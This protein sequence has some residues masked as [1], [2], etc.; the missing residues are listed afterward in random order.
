MTASTL[1]LS[2]AVLAALVFT[3][4]PRSDGQGTG[5]TTASE[6]GRASVSAGGVRI[7]FPPENPGLRLIR[8]ERITKCTATLPAVMPARV[9]ASITSGL[10]SHERMVLFES[11]DVA[12]LYS[13]YRQNRANVERTA[14][15]L[16]RVRE[17]YDNQTATSKDLNEAETDAANARASSAES[18]AK[19][20]GLGFN[21]LELES[22]PTGTIWLICDVPESQ[23]HEVQKGEVVRIVFDAYPNVQFS[24]HADALGEVVDAVTRTVRVR[25]SA[26]NPKGKFLPGMFARVDFGDP[27][28]NIVLLP[29]SAIVTV[30]GSDYVFVR[31][32]QTEFERRQVALASSGASQVVVLTGVA[33][34]EQ[35]VTEGAMLLKGLSFG[36]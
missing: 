26:A 9:V 23:L 15:A 10:A 30:E 32:G 6:F 31:S 35:V 3:G 21:P 5:G 16:T 12:T 19:L 36:Y 13:Q 29:T 2:A 18:E 33:D 4:C 24:G 8:T 34:G 11:G 25:V 1:Q 14:K 20:R 28:D 7:G 27:A 22:V 17:M